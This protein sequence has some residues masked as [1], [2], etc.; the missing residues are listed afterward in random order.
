[1]T[2]TDKVM[3]KVSEGKSLSKADKETLKWAIDRGKDAKNEDT[4]IT[5]AKRTGNTE[6]EKLV[7]KGKDLASDIPNKASKMNELERYDKALYRKLYKANNVIER[8]NGWAKKVPT[9]RDMDDKGRASSK[10]SLKSIVSELE[11]LSK[12]VNLSQVDK[13]IVQAKKKKEME[14]NV[15]KKKEPFKEKVKRNMKEAAVDKEEVMN[16]AYDIAL[17]IYGEDV[18]SSIVK[19]MVDK[20]LK[21]ANSEKEAI[22]ILKKMSRYK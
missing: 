21:K 10:K 4:D 20:A 9:L 13:S 11:K 17:E 8:L 15:M 14:Q 7:K 3:K 16:A 19:E 1:M 12:E 18:K 22:G 6:L 2:K 5:E